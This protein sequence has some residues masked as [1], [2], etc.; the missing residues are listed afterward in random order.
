MNNAQQKIAVTGATGRLGSHLVELLE[1]SGHEVVSISRS[2]GVDVITGEGLG[3][4]LVGVDTVVDTATGPT[5]DK[6]AATQFFVTSARNL[7]EAGEQAGV[8]RIVGVSII[9][10]DRFTGGTYGGYY[11]AKATQERALLDGPIPAQILRA[12]QFHE[13]VGQLLDWSTQGDVAYVPAMRTQLVAARSV[14]EALADLA[15]S[16]DAAG[17]GSAI[18]E[19]AG[20]RVERLVD[21]ARLVAS[22]R[23]SP[24]QVEEVSDPDDPDRDLYAGDGLLPG[25]HAKLAGPTFEE[26]LDS[27]AAGETGAS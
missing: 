22:R 13:F 11:V 17:P 21:V 9:G 20:P 18:P 19:I 10:C 6:D 26:W 1:G 8:R 12:A 2:H 25:P 5:P 24:A 27:Q 14:A 7:E 3:E 16:S 23:G 15:T 4:A